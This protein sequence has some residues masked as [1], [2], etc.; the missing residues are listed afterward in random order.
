ME[1]VRKHKNDIVGIS[2]KFNY[3]KNPHDPSSYRIYDPTIGGAMLDLGVY[4]YRVTR[5][6]MNEMGMEMKD[7]NKDQSKI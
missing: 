5:D 7:Y 6:I 1:L 4:V 3:P 2:A